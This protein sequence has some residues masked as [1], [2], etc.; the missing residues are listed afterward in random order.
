[1][2]QPDAAGALLAIALD[3][4][5]ELYHEA[6]K[7][8]PALAAEQFAAL[9]RFAGEPALRR[10]AERPVRRHPYR[11]TVALPAPAWPAVALRDAFAGRRS[12]T[13]LGAGDLTLAHLSLVLGAAA[14][15]TGTIP[16]PAGGAIGGR[17]A[18]SGGGLYPLDLHVLPLRCPELAPRCH[19]Y[20]PERHALEIGPRPVE[21]ERLRQA[22]TQQEI[23]DGAGAIVVIA[24]VFARSRVKYGLRAYR[25]VLLEAGHVAQCALL[26]AAAAGLRSL[27]VGGVVDRALE[28]II[29]LDG[30]DESFVH[31][32]AV[33]RE[34]GA[35]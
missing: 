16:G 21:A 34:A 9:R 22:V 8:E 30:V 32:F 28:Q 14:G 27:P 13:D 23:V 11:D 25:H 2:P 7:I 17:V 29:G 35:P 3:D 18:P 19:L 1:M 4:P 6:S 26:A 24:G 31:A 5:A 15:S 10:A 20:D 12:T 33:G